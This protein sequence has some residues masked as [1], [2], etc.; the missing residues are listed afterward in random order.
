MYTY[1]GNPVEGVYRRHPGTG[2]VLQ[3]ILISWM[4]NTRREE[5]VE[6][7][8][9]TRGL[10]AGRR[11]PDNGVG[12]AHPHDGYEAHGDPS[13]ETRLLVLYSLLKK[14]RDRLYTRLIRASLPCQPASQ[15]T[16]WATI[17]RY[18]HLNNNVMKTSTTIL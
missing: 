10:T 11:P 17:H 1:C 5:S 12:N 9:Q 4:G 2:S 3:L 7:I 15:P 18:T 13:L 8:K 14:R 16:G 6:G